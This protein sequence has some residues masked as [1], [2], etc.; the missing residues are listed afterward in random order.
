MARKAV[1]EGIRVVDA[2]LA[3]IVEDEQTRMA[4]GAQADGAHAVPAR[5]PRI[6][7]PHPSHRELMV[8]WQRLG[9][10]ERTAWLEEAEHAGR[11]SVRPGDGLLN[12]WHTMR[13]CEDAGGSVPQSIT[14]ARQQDRAT[15]RREDEQ[16]CSP[17]DDFGR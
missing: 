3:R 9:G 16:E 10:Y 17:Q 8:W 1:R 12:A 7:R 5:V 4:R 2:D 13:D 15:V 6:V 11:K 14:K